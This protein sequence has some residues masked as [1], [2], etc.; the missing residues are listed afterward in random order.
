M[1][2]FILIVLL[3][4]DSSLAQRPAAPPAFEVAS[5][6]PSNPVKGL[7]GAYTYPGGRVFVGHST[8]NDLV[9]DAFEVQGFQVK[10]GAAW[11]RSDQYDIDARPPASSE[12]AK[13]QPRTIQQPMNGEQR[14]MLRSLLAD[15]FGFRFHR[16][17]LE[18][19]VLLLSKGRKPKLNP[20]EDPK[21]YSWVGS[22]TDNGMMTGTGI[23]GVNASMALLADR[24]QW[25]FERPVIDRT[26]IP[27]VFDF[28]FATAWEGPPITSSKSIRS[29]EV[30]ANI[31]A[32]VQGIGLKL[33]PGKAP[34]ETIVIDAVEKP[35]PN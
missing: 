13:P 25:Y 23:R 10:G 12:S 11:T 32:A 29:P 17:E 7:V 26:G 28:K 16:E 30:L 3:A 14:Q 2:R 20:P 18:G 33:E 8:L 19:D 27:G 5:I 34:I 1:L 9:A 35:A 22:A 21:V 24:L 4:T 15:R 6:K 31:V